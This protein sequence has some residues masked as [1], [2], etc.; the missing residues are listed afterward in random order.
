MKRA[1]VFFFH[2]CNSIPSFIV[3]QPLGRDGLNSF[4]YSQC[5]IDLDSQ[6]ICTSALL[7]GVLEILEGR[8]TRR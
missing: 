7:H 6:I 5:G 1:L 4:P 3:F 8:R 2:D